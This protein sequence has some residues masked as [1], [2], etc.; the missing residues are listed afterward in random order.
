MSPAR[1]E[2]ATVCISS[3]A[4][5][6]PKGCCADNDSEEVCSALEGKVAVFG[7]AKLEAGFAFLLT[8]FVFDSCTHFE[9]R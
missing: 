8:N 7:L 1:I 2:R 4:G 6:N 9:S 3:R 5:G